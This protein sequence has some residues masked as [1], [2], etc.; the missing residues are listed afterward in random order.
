MVHE[1]ST[2]GECAK[3]YFSSMKLK[4]LWGVSDKVRLALSSADWWSN[5][6]L[7]LGS[8]RV[9]CA[10]VEVVLIHVYH[11]QRANALSAHVL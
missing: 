2:T 6:W 3:A 4:T 7:R 9:A 8:H 1:A 5:L 11:C 10:L